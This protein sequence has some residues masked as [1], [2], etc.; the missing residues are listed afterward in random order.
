M[1]AAAIA[2]TK[3]LKRE[4]EEKAAEQ[5]QLEEEAAALRRHEEEEAAEKERL[6]LARAAEVRK[7]V[8]DCD[9][10]ERQR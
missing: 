3:Q 4:R 6:R 8:S 5:R 1:V 9:W 2:R 7:L 10:P